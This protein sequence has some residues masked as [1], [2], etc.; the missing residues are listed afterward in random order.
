MSEN[1]QSQQ[2]YWIVP[3]YNEEDGVYIVV[4]TLLNVGILEKN[5]ILI[6]DGS[7]KGEVLK[8]KRDKRYNI[9]IITHEN[10]KGQGAALRSGVEF[11]KKNGARYMVTI[12][13]D[14]Q[15]LVNDSLQMLN[16]LHQHNNIE[17]VI[18]SRF[19]GNAVNI[20]FSRKIILKI[21]ILFTFITT[22]KLFTDVHNGLRVFRSSFF[23]KFTITEDG[24]AHA[25]EILDCLA[26]KN[27]NYKEF[28]VTVLYSNHTL[29]KGQGWKSLFKITFQVLRA[30]FK[31]C[32]SVLRKYIL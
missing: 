25:S 2:A 27:I 9:N 3:C 1:I 28:P 19:L 6:D 16:F 7:T 5:I 21:A 32:W 29:K 24:M 26:R 12:D 23:E 22:G 8:L 13:S 31:L 15:H 20:P 30:K 11:A 10:N 14:G 4:D 18:G 17:V